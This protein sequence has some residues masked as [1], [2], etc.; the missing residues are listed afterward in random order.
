MVKLEYFK[1][2]IGVYENSLPKRMCNEIIEEF[3]KKKDLHYRGFSLGKP[4][5]KQDREFFDDVKNTN[6][7]RISNQQIE[8]FDDWCETFEDVSLDN[9]LDLLGKFGYHDRFEPNSVLSYGEVFW[10]LWKLNSYEKNKG[11]YNAFHTEQPYSKGSCDRLFVTIFY[12]NDVEEGG[13]T[14]F[15]YSDIEIKPKAGTSVVW[16]AGWPWVHRANKPVS[17][18]KYII[19]SWMCANWGK[20]L[21]W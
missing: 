21:P 15:P 14:C 1:D 20:E 17:N 8:K 18:K 4:D 3:E 12:L 10:P 13:E 5:G 2:T 9:V 7:M 19:T 6:E 11:H 16:P